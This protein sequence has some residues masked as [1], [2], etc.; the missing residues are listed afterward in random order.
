M[1]VWRHLTSHWSSLTTSD[2]LTAIYLLLL[3]LAA[4]T[5]NHLFIRFINSKPEGR[6]TVLG[7][8]NIP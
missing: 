3:S 6:K 7:L 5:S 2:T 1:E 4:V 8:H